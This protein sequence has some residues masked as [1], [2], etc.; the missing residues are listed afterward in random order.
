M[1]VFNSFIVSILG[2]T[3]LFSCQKDTTLV[4]N[5]NAPGVINSKDTIIKTPE[6]VDSAL[7]LGNPTGAVTD[8]SDSLNYLLK[9]KNSA[10]KNESFYALSYNSRKGHANWVSWHV[11]YADVSG[12]TPRQDN[13]RENTNLPFQW[14]RATDVSYNGSGFDRGHMCPSADRVSSVDAN[15]STFLMTNM[16]PQAPRNNQITWA[17]LEDSCRKLVQ[18]GN[19]LYIIAGTYGEGGSFTTS[20]FTTTI[21]NGKISVPA[22]LWKVVLVLSNGS[23]DLNRVTDATRVIAINIPNANDVN[24]NWKNYRVSI[25]Q[26]ESAVGNNLNIF[27]KLPVAIQSALKAKVDNL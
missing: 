8:E 15:S 23:D 27:S 9:E 2:L 17:S 5:T 7:L 26:I 12:N 21:C 4:D 19:E 1:K 20:N 13:F 16:V 6:S 3:V 11:T 25:N 14:F 18:A 10:N 24:S 22:N